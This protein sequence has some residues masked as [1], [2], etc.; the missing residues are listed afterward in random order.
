VPLLPV[1][2]LAD[3]R[4]RDYVA[5]T[6]VNLRRALEPAEGLFMAESTKVIRRALAA[7]HRM[8]SLLLAP[9]WV[10]DIPDLIE[11][12]ERDG[13]P[14]FVADEATLEQITGFHLHRGSLAAMHR[15]PLRPVADV[16]AGLR[17][18][19]VLEDLV[20]HTN[21]GAVFRSA[22]A[23]G[24]EALLVTPNCADPFYRRSVR[25]SMGSVFS[26]P[27]TRT[28]DWP[29]GLAELSELGFR[30]A[31]L[32]LTD[33]AEDLD[34]LAADPPE[35]LCWILGSEG[36]GL[37]ARTMEGADRVVKIPMA[38]G[39]DSLNAAAAAAVA[40]WSTR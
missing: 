25:V 31:A 17:R 11:A 32:G 10:D 2:D 30:T 3:P 40:F 8:R 1:D 6:D 16:V 23:L 26:V 5:L 18:I 20:D 29:A 35:R 14:A 28:G 38:A 36:P 21:V 19:A 27:W 7:G 15:P 34:A 4:L 24:V 13:A 9:Q 37:T 33:G 39:V 22:A 12:A